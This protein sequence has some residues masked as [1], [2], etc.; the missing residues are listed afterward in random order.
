[1]GKGT[2]LK[3]LKKFH[4]DLYNNLTRVVLYN[5]RAPRPG[6]TDGVEFHFRP[7]KYIEKQ[8]KK[9]DLL[10]LEVRGDLHA[11]DVQKLRKIVGKGDALLIDSPFLVKALR[12][13]PL[14]PKVPVVAIMLV[15]LTREEVLFFKTLETQV[16]SFSDLVADFMRRKLLRRSRRQKNI[17]SLKDLEDIEVRSHNA[18]LEL[19]EAHRFDH[20]LVNHEGGDNEYW[21]S[22]YYPVGDPRKTLMAFAELLRGNTPAWAEKWEEDLVP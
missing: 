7:R 8:I 1:M 2:L 11:L 15:P 10:A 16:F 17:L 22:F 19:K 14:L 21:S 12:E 9:K 6:E 18:Y 5:S 3:M 20:I 4:R 13:H